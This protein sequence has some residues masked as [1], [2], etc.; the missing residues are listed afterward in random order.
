M[1][2]EESPH[3]ICPSSSSIET[4]T[5]ATSA[6][7]RLLAVS[8]HLSSSS[9]QSPSNNNNTITTIISNAPK[10]TTL[11]TAAKPKITCHVLDTTQGRPGAGIPATLTCLS[12]HSTTSGSGSA[13]QRKEELVSL[14]GNSY[15]GV[16]NADGR[17]GSWAHAN[18]GVGLNELLDGALAETQKKKNDS[19][20]QGEKGGEVEVQSSWELRF[21]MR[22][23]WE[24]KG[25][26]SFFEDVVVRFVVRKVGAGEH[27]HVPVLVGPFSYTTYRGS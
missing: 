23:Y 15:K 5:K 20:T 22:V 12:A 25:V 16:T 13:T 4:Q 1:H 17:I 26:Q 6:T 19:N 14:K 18:F 8:T 21:E 24:G 9:S 3:D 2:P 27:Y 10:M 7:T 11:S